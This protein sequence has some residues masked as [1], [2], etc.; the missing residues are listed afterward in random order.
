MC[1]PQ[2]SFTLNGELAMEVRTRIAAASATLALL[3]V[4]ACG[5]P[6]APA[7]NPPEAAANNILSGTLEQTLSLRSGR[8]HDRGRGRESS[9]WPRHDRDDLPGQGN[10]GGVSLISCPSNETQTATGLIGLLGGTLSVGGTTVSIPAGALTV[11]L[12]IRI[13]VPSSPYMKVDVSAL[14]LLHLSFLKPIRITID[15][16]RCN[17]SDIDSA[18]LEVWYLDDGTNTPIENMGGVDN[19]LARTITFSTGHFS[20]YAVAN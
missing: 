8:G 15:Y 13:T 14:G 19:K 7:A 12:P 5:E 9:G 4:F 18:P 3:T 16:S 17:R 1:E 6:T 2:S 20:G 11:A 10:S